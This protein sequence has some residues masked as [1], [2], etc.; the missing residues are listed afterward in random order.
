MRI[1]R[2]RSFRIVAE[3]DA[4][5]ALQVRLMKFFQHFGWFSSRQKWKRTF[6]LKERVA[7]MLDDT[8]M[9]RSAQILDDIH[10]AYDEVLHFVLTPAT[11]FIG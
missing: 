6:A 9:P 11:R 3:L 1:D 8:G 2:S 10:F 5:Y 4:L 7:F